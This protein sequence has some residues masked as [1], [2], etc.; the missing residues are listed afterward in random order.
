MDQKQEI[1]EK[2]YGS[3]T[4]YGYYQGYFPPIDP[5]FFKAGERKCFVLADSPEDAKKKLRSLSLAYLNRLKARIA[6]SSFSDLSRNYS[7]RTS[8]DNYNYLLIHESKYS[9]VEFVGFPE[10]I[11]A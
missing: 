7:E 1:K 6:N 8:I 5:G 3:N 11:V 4:Q 9:E 2:S 10:Q